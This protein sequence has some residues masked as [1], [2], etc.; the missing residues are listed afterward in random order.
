MYGDEV[1]Q[2]LSKMRRKYI[3]NRM[4]TEEEWKDTMFIIAD[5]MQEKHPGKYQ[6]EEYYNPIKCYWDLRLT[7]E[8]KAKETMFLLKWS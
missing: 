1:T 6:I 3:T 7:F 8:D 4:L 2:T 5:K